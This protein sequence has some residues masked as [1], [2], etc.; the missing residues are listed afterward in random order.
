VT[1]LGPIGIRSHEIGRGDL[2]EAVE[3]LVEL[4]EL[5]ASAVWIGAD[6]LLD[7]GAQLAAASFKTK[8]ASSVASIW[9]HEPL[10]IASSYRSLD[11]AHPGRFMLGIGV[12][13]GPIVERMVP[14]KR[15]AKP[16]SS[17]LCW[18]DELDSAPRSVS[19]DE[20][21]IGAIWPRMLGVARDRA[22]GAHPYL[23]SPAHTLA[24][25]E[26][27]GPGPLLAPAQVVVL[28]R[29][30]HRAR[31]IGRR[32]L[33]SPYMML[34]NYVRNWLRYGFAPNDVAAG[35][36]DRLI[37]GLIAWG[38]AERVAGRVREHFE[39]GADHV[40]V[41]VVTADGAA[42]PRRQWR[43]LTAALGRTTLS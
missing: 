40:A 21:V 27:L 37:D 9:A 20:R 36:S 34:P 22:A 8:I 10:E 1:G 43:E 17:M 5:G 32:H 25:R 2:G 23:V 31:E 6:A 29:D 39:A 11:E 41:Q 12:S 3:A 42:F 35:G 15:Y 24:A 14:S 38:D 28:E 30:P 4:E 19:S 26:I 33:N 13:H 7:R 16:V 18:L